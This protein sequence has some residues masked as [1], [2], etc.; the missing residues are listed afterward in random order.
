MNLL[1]GIWGLLINNSII[2]IFFAL[3]IFRCIA[4][5]ILVKRDTNTDN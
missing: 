2:S 5:L 3:F 1:N 4:R